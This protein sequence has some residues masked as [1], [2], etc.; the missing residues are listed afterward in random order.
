[1]LDLPTDSNR[2]R[3]LHDFLDGGVAQLSAPCR[4]AHGWCKCR[5]YMLRSWNPRGFTRGVS[6]LR[7]CDLY[8]P[9]NLKLSGKYTHT[10]TGLR[11]LFPGFYE[12]CIMMPS[13]NVRLH[14]QPM[15]HAFTTATNALCAVP[16]RLACMHFNMPPTEAGTATL[17]A[18]LC[19]RF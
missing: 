17:Y 5:T 15:R 6:L 9:S 12:N 18:M 11:L 2:E 7:S 4:Q 16:A 13:S 8:R 14:V 19:P 1:M 10:F 3:A